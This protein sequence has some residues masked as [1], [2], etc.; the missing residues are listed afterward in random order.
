MRLSPESHFSKINVINQ[1]IKNNLLSALDYLS[2]LIIA[3]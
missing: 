2:F 1:K 3:E